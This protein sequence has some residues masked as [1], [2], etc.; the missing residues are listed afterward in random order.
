L[1]DDVS[2]SIKAVNHL[3]DAGRKRVAIC[4]GNLNLLISQNRLQ[5]YKTALIEKGIPIV[6]EFIISCETPEETE[7]ETFRLLNMKNPPDSIFAISDLTMTGVM[8]AIFRKNLKVPN[9]IS[10]IGFC[11]EP[12]RSM[13]NP[14]L[15]A[16]QPMGFEIGKKA[17]ELLFE[18]LEDNTAINIQ[19]RVI[20]LDSNLVE[21]G[22][23]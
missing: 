22:T 2:G 9:D 18:R 11:E 14:P 6:E 16:I 5:G 7:Q 12:F 17:A 15:S 20:Y 1:V 10:V 8:K 13:Y 3:V 4:V 21:G 19:P 23:T